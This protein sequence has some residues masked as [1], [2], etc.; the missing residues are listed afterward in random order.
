M[1][2]AL[3]GSFIIM[4]VTFLICHGWDKKTIAAFGGTAVS[5]IV[6]ALLAYSFSIYAS[7]MGTADEEML[8]LLSEFET[9]DARGILLAA[10]II[11]TLGVLDD[12]TIAQASAVFELKKANTQMTIQQLYRS[13][14]R[15]GSDHIAAAI[16]TLILAYV[17][18]SLP[19]I[20]LVVA[21]PTGESW[22]TFLNRE[23]VAQ[24]IVRALVGSIG[25]LAAVPLTTLFAALLVSRKR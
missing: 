21:I 19:L 5:L 23:M 14:H 20:L 2:I 18:T 1:Y 12:V 9:L 15:I 11:G 13:A 10:I 6:T 24:E 22:L 4:I 16:N 3:V 8:F 7:L 25:L 17:G